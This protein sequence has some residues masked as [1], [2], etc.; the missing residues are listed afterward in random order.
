MYIF[1]FLNQVLVDPIRIPPAENKSK[2]YFFNNPFGSH[3]KI[4]HQIQKY[5]VKD[6]GIPFLKG[7]WHFMISSVVWMLELSEV[8]AKIGN[9]WQG[10]PYH[11][12]TM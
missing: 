8:E 4:S 5:V 3:S 9:N 12:M 1:R 6:H 10:L 2:N 11:K 7:V